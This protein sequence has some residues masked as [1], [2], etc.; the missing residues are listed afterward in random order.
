M[1]CGDTPLCTSIPSLFALAVTKE[2]WV[3]DY[4]SNPEEGEGWNP[5]FTRSFNDREMEEA[6][7]LLR[8][9]GQHVVY[10]DSEDKVC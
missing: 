6:E 8:R 10:D 1:W 3:R 4:W 9:L 7:R 5:L 2:A